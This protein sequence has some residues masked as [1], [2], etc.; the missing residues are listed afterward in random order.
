LHGIA[1]YFGLKGVGHEGL[2]GEEWVRAHEDK[3]VA[4]TGENGLR[5]KVLDNTCWHLLTTVT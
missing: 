5:E 3:W 2:R 1:E 4:W